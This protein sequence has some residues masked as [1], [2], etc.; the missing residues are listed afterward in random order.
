MGNFQKMEVDIIG[1]VAFDGEKIGD[2]FGW[3]MT[4]IFNGSSWWR[5]FFLNY[6]NFVGLLFAAAHLAGMLF[7]TVGLLFTAPPKAAVFYVAADNVWNFVP[8]NM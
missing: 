3:S 8:M 4:R 7:S 5:T 6:R 2:I 1:M